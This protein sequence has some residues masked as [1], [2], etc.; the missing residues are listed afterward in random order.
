MRR[1]T[2]S[3][4][5]LGAPWRCPAGATLSTTP[6]TGLCTRRDAIR[7]TPSRPLGVWGLPGPRVSPS[8]WPPSPPRSLQKA[9]PG[10]VGPSQQSLTL[11][12]S[13]QSS[14]MT[15][16][17]SLAPRHRHGPHDATAR[18]SWT[19]MHVD[20]RLNFPKPPCTRPT[21]EYK[22]EVRS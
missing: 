20:H 11:S 18:P 15:P 5:G 7:Q 6:P 22:G 1:Y 19:P 12:V 14:Q 17:A 4:Q 10:E 16:K 9:H 21:S 2:S 13:E 8:N 3:Q